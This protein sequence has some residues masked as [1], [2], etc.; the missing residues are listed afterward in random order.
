MGSPTAT[1]ELTFSH[2]ITFGRA[3]TMEWL[4]EGQEVQKYAIQVMNGAKWKT[5][6]SG[7]TIGHKKIDL[8]SPTTAQKVRLNILSASPTPRIR[9]FQ[10]FDGTQ[11]Q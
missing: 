8:F 5:I 1:I 4:V 3:L 10:L 6:Y 11:A 2:P 7:T 9:K